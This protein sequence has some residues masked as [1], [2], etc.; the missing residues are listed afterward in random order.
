CSCTRSA[1]SAQ[2]QPHPCTLSATVRSS[3][4]RSCLH[5]FCDV[6]A[7]L[8]RD[9]DLDAFSALA[10]NPR[11]LV[12]LG[13]HQHDVAGVNRRFH[14]EDAA[15][16]IRRGLH[17][18]LDEVDPLDHHAIAAELL[19][20]T[21]TTLVVAA[22][23]DDIVTHSKPLHHNTSGASEMIFMNFLWRSS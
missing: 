6:L 5:R 23:H 20:A 10:A 13:I 18:A 12:R 17:V 4:A 19:H 1:S 16:L 21:A 7:A 11:G 3:L 14:L 15:G 9:P 8:H 22:G 2:V